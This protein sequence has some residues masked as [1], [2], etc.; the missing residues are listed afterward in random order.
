MKTTISLR[1]DSEIN[2]KLSN[3][4]NENNT[5]KTNV[6]LTALSLLIDN[7][8]SKDNTEVH[9]QIINAFNQYS[10]HLAQVRREKVELKTD[11]LLTSQ[12]KMLA[13]LTKLTQQQ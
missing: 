11:E 2:D 5:S 9:M 13:I 4:A 8:H 6:I 12:Q 10:A 3:Y 1:I 7:E